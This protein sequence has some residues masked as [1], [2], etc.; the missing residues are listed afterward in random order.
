MHNAALAVRG[1]EARYARFH[2]R[3]DE[4]A[5]A[6]GLLPALGFIGVNLTVPYKLAALASMHEIDAA[7]QRLG[8][9]NTV[10]VRDAQLVGANTDGDGISGAIRAEFGRSLGEL[11]VLLLGAGGGAGRAI[12]MQCAAE[13]CPE[14]RLANRTFA[15]AEALCAELSAMPSANVI[16]AVPWN[17]DELGAASATSDL[18]INATSIGLRA[19][20]PP[21]LPRSMLRAGQWVYDTIY[22]P[23]RTPLLLEAEAAGA[24]A[25]NGLSMLLFQGARSFEHWFGAPAPVSAMRDALALMS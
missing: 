14:L 13:R 18:I 1:I 22:N 5:P 4:L 6:L 12:A 15:K 9:I 8:A 25:A 11:R 24:R 19:T 17:E 10:I 2:I 20:D 16:A 3:P 7:A 23:T 21:V